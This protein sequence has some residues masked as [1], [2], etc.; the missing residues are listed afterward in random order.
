MKKINTNKSAIFVTI[1]IWGIICVAC[2]TSNTTE[3]Q[4][5]LQEKVV[6]KNVIP[7][8]KSEPIMQLDKP[9]ESREDELIKAPSKEKVQKQKSDEKKFTFTDVAGVKYTLTISWSKKT[10]I[11]KDNSNNTYYGKYCPG[12][13]SYIRYEEPFP[14][15][16]FPGM[17]SI[18][19][20]SSFH[21]IPS[22]RMN[23][24][25]DEA[26]CDIES[27]NHCLKLTEIE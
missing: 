11:L 17:R 3:N 4:T 6:E 25:D 7:E 24:Y 23:I 19:Y 26:S 9:D 21:F 22:S 10:A 5:I 2:N 18:R 1:G 27:P 16:Y 13:T 12:T 15:V 14:P 20:P 8:T